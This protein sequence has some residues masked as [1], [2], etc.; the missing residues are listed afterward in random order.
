M[1]CGNGV[2]GRNSAARNCGSNRATNSSQLAK[3]PTF[4]MFPKIMVPPNHPF[5]HRVYHYKPSILGYPFFGNTHIFSRKSHEV[6]TFS[7][8]WL[9]QWKWYVLF[10]EDIIQILYPMWIYIYMWRYSWWI[11]E[12]RCEFRLC[13]PIRWWMKLVGN[14]SYRCYGPMP[15]TSGHPIRPIA[16]QPTCAKGMFL[17]YVFCEKKRWHSPW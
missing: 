3:R 11:I 6:K 8:T 13:E 4:K 17:F 1:F 7:P 9:S 5:V 10:V 15:W 2:F 16:L 12:F 14:W